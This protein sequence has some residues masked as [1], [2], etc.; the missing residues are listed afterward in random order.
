MHKYQNQDKVSELKSGLSTLFV[1][2]IL[3]PPVYDMY[4]KCS[5]YCSWVE[6]QA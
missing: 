6:K 3:I 1:K 4:L 2:Y 5:L